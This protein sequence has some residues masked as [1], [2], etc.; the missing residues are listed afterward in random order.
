MI[1]EFDLG[2]ISLD[3]RLT[4]HNI[5][6]KLMSYLFWGMP[7]LASVNAG[8]DLFACLEESGAGACVANG[9]DEALY[10]AALRL[11]DDAIV[12]DRMG[13]AARRLL[14]EKFSVENAVDSIFQHIESHGLLQIPAVEA[15]RLRPSM[16]AIP[17]FAEKQ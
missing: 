8:N 11:V 17:E 16:G 4:T 3:A 10:R 15:Q 7:V 12:R 9:D 1:S 13:R 5:P 6:G 14:E 2:L